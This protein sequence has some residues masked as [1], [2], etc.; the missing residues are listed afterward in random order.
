VTNEEKLLPVI[1][2]FQNKIRNSEFVIDKSG[3]KC[4]EII[5]AAILLDP[6]QPVLNFTYRKT[7]L[8]YVRAELA[9]YD[10]QDLRIERIAP[11]AKM[12][13]KVSDKD[14]YVNSNYGWMIYSSENFNQFENCAR[15]LETN[16]DSRRAVMIYQRPSMWAEYL[17]NGKS[18][19]VCTDGTQ[20]FIRENKL[21]YI[22]KQRSCDFIF[23]FFNDFY[24]H[25][26]VH[27]RM[28]E[29][30]RLT[31][32]DLTFGVLVYDAFSLHV[33]ERH[34]ELIEKIGELHGL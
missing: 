28:L 14:G 22:V 15:E 24:W 5:N 10:S 27:K 18:D 25:C 1:K 3:V 23:G 12:W 6:H 26:E 30:L 31:Y 16:P 32:S 34:F 11:H 17:E 20:L 19:F 2:I 29:R 8:E 13:E 21:V 33:Y 9:W 4:V 7:P